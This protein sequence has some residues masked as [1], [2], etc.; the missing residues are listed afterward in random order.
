M[1][2]QLEGFTNSFQVTSTELFTA[3]ITLLK[4]LLVGNL[5]VK[6]N[7]KMK[8]LIMKEGRIAADEDS[9]G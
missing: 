9:N 2:N 1:I 5:Y 8:K 3:M 6:E 7:G 4:L